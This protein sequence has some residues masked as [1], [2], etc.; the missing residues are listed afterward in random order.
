[1]NNI[2]D[3]EEEEPRSLTYLEKRMTEMDD[4]EETTF[5][6]KKCAR[7]EMM[8]TNEKEQTIPQCT[9]SLEIS[10]NDM[11]MTPSKIGFV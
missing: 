6:T 3:N 7:D 8:N 5:I 11:N 9:P 4:E 2:V 1:M 10:S